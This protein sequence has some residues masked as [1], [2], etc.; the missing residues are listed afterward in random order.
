MDN[1]LAPH[2]DVV[3]ASKSMHREVLLSYRLLFG[4]HR[5]SRDLFN[6]HEMTKASWHGSIDPLLAR[7][8]GQSQDI[9]H[10][11]QD[12]PMIEQDFYDTIIEFP[13]LGPRLEILQKYARSRRPRQFLDVWRDTR[14]PTQW[15][16]IW[17][18]VTIGGA[19]V[20]F[21]IMQIVLAFIQT[22]KIFH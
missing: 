8:C 20:V 19:T 14:D 3:S 4:Q 11:F 21:S 18:V 17:V 7:I 13:F 12:D 10:L 6:S 9:S 1:Y 2:P 15:L 16:T 22:I 5:K